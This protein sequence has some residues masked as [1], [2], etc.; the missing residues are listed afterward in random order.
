MNN[1]GD[2]M[3]LFKTIEA[4]EARPD[5]DE[6]FAQTIQA[7]ID[8]TGNTPS[9]FEIAIYDWAV[10]GTGHAVVDAKAGSGKTT[11]LTNLLK[12]IPCLNKVVLV[13]FNKHIAE[14]LTARGLPNNATAR[15]LHSIGFEASPE[16]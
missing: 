10:N 1:N 6:L 12:F 16:P 4:V 9:H 11:V 8:E 14:T 5:A 2:N 13:A 15:T 7:I 3:D